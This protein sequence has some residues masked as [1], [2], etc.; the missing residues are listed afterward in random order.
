MRIW[1]AGPVRGK[2]RPRFVRATGRTYTP[3]ETVSY[4]A[5]LRIA[6]QLA[7]DGR[8]PFAGQVE[9]T[10]VARFEVPKAFSRLKRQ[11][12]LDGVLRPTRKP[13]LD[14]I[15]KL[16]D[17]LNGVVWLDDRQI[18]DATLLKRYSAEPGLLI[19]VE[20]A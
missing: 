3:P 9:I 12:A 5:A 14:N 20:A 17:A 13:D 18:T 11:Q 8:P 6:A 1:L 10:M 4:E 7:M 19:T 2:G 16:A 15:A